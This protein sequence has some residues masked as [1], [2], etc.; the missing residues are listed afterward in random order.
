MDRFL[1]YT[2]PA[3]FAGI[4]ISVL[5]WVFSA[6]SKS[7]NS[8]P[9]ARYATGALQNLDT[10]DAGQLA[11]DATFIN[12]DGQAISY[13]AFS[14]KLILVNFWAT[15]CGPCEREMPSLAAL[16][17][18]RGSDKFEVVAIS[19]DSPG[20]KDYAAQRLS[21]LSGGVLDF[22]M[23]SD[24]PAGWDIIY[25]S[26][27]GGGFPTSILINAEGRHIA[28]LEGEADWTSYEAIGLIDAV[29]SN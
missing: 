27:A 8:N 28:K 25:E 10:A 9:V 5:F 15:W 2:I 13:N 1:R 11:S 6:S 23:I 18:A 19:V 3:M 29:L 16:Q 21:E 14:G 20:D 17:T 7:S 26:G 24:E 22:Y 4:L 12:T